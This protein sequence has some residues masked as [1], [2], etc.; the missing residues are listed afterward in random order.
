MI[1]LGIIPSIQPTHATSDMEYA[2]AR[3][4]P[5]RLAHSAYRQR[6]FF[7]AG[8]P[9]VLGSDFPVEPA[10]PFAGIYAALTRRSP[11]DGHSANRTC[12]DCG[13]YPEQRISLIQALNGFGNHTAWGAFLDAK[14][15]GELKIG[16]WADWVVVDRNIW[17]LSPEGIRDLKVLETWV[18]GRKVWDRENK[19]DPTLVWRWWRHRRDL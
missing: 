19:P 5:V 10:T 7:E 13:W 8:L 15:V 9:V 17:K 4:G 12:P 3:L 14:G 11:E 2:L 16:G 18:G 6:S 1:N